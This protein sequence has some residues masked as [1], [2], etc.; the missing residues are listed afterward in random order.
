[1]HCVVQNHQRQND[2]KKS[3]D[4]ES[5]ADRTDATMPLGISVRRQRTENH[6]PPMKLDLDPAYNEATKYTPKLEGEQS[7]IAHE[8]KTRSICRASL[9]T[10][11]YSA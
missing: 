11:R 9:T 4:A 6:A 10:A 1:M 7:K 2:T 5:G 3:S 8:E